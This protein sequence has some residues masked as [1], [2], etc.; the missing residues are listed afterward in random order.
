MI[1]S[2]KVLLFVA[3][4]AAGLCLS[5]GQT[6]TVN[7]DNFS[8]TPSN[9]DALL[10][11]DSSGVALTQGVATSNTDGALIQLGYFSGGTTANNFAGTWIPITGFGPTLH[12]SIG[13]SPDLS[14]GGLGIIFF[15]TFFS[16]N[17]NDV[18]VYSPFPPTPDPGAYITQSSIQITN[19]TPPNNQ[20]L[21]IRF[22]DTTT[23]TS[24][25]YNT[26]SA[27]DWLWQTPNTSGPIVSI[28]LETNVFFGGAP[29]EFEDFNNPFE[30]AI[31][32][33]E[34]STYA[35]LMLGLLGAAI[36][37]RRFKLPR[38]GSELPTPKGAFWGQGG[39]LGSE[40][41]IVN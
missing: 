15:N 17:T 19:T 22:Y 29:L 14:G 2:K 34:P 6:T 26:V 20:V 18:Q 24:G 36:G 30:T 12:T 39:V 32:I 23:G 11:R 4:T 7:W 13:D 35:L 5:H 33:P 3:A 8:G 9:Q 40:L 41:P 28:N 1:M 16:L 25:N 21:A 38:L 31:L 10:F 27:D 37:R